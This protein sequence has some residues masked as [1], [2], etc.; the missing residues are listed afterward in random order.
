MMLL[1]KESKDKAL[2]AG[3]EPQRCFSVNEMK[4]GLFWQSCRCRGWNT[5]LCNLMVTTDDDEVEDPKNQAPWMHEYLHGMGHEVYGFLPA[6][7]FHGWTFRGMVKEAYRISGCIVFAAQIDGVVVLAPLKHRKAGTVVV[8]ADMVF[9]VL[10]QDEEELRGFALDPAVS[11]WKAVFLQQRRR[12]F[13]EMAARREG[14]AAGN[15]S[16]T[17]PA[18]EARRTA[19]AAQAVDSPEGSDADARRQSKAPSQKSPL[20]RGGGEEE[21]FPRG[22]EEARG[23]RSESASNQAASPS[24]SSESGDELARHTT[25]TWDAFQRQNSVMALRAMNEQEQAP[26]LMRKKMA[27]RAEEIKLG[28]EANP[29][30]LVLDFS[31]S[32]DTVLSFLRH[33]RSPLL[34]FRMRVVVLCSMALTEGAAAQLNMAQDGQ[35]GI[36]QGSPNW[37]PD[38]RRSGVT[39]CSIIVCLGQDGT[40]DAHFTGELVAMLD[41]DVVM[42]QRMLDGMG[43]GHKPMIFEFKRVQNMRLLQQP[44]RSE[45][46]EE[47]AN[48]ER[49][50]LDHRFASGEIF[51]AQPLG[52]LLAHAFH[53][54]GIL[55][56]MQ[57]LI[58]GS[59]HGKDSE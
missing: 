32:W 43:L 11:N 45:L 39:E 50:F 58:N 36:L 15:G 44:R 7:K 57:A 38:I 30:V 35:L 42:L 5:L 17:R 2:S 53:T 49:Y 1:M 27:E 28:G 47:A 31:Q 26:F 9:F 56:V 19:R 52:S 12:M 29:F 4:S 3:I 16:S 59:E 33:N 13:A 6:A 23:S 55:E 37:P 41:A 25:L 22:P 20:L 40:S 8:T 54:P 14:D 10:A 51:A 46:H 21:A 24:E 48:D 18:T 34:P